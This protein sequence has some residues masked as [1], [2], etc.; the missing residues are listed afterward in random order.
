MP[1]DNKQSK[2]NLRSRAKEEETRKRRSAESS[3][4]DDSDW[5]EEQ[6]GSPE[7]DQKEYKKFLQKLFP[8]KHLADKIK[9]MEEIDAK[10]NS[11]T[12]SSK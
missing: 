1:K 10:M 7:L 2:Y 9:E 11:S 3:D 4:D 6:E 8:S 12:K 5:E